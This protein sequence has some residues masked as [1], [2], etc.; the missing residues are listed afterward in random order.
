MGCHM[1]RGAAESCGHLKITKREAIDSRVLQKGSQ[2]AHQLRG[3][4]HR[5]LGVLFAFGECHPW[6]ARLSREGVVC[7]HSAHVR[8]NYTA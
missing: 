4:E 5:T 8:S 1:L 2:P 7:K 3:C 6:H